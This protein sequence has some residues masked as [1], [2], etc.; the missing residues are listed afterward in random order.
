M[1]V[2][3]LAGSVLKGSTVRLARSA[4]LA[5]VLLVVA[6]CGGSGSAP[7]AEPA[8]S[9]FAAAVGASSDDMLG[10]IVSARMESLLDDEVTRCMKRQGFEYLT[11]DWTVSSS[12][13]VGDPGGDLSD[14]Q[15][16]SELGFGIY[17][18]A[19]APGPTLPDPTT[20][21]SPNDDYLES[22][23]ETERSAWSAQV[24][25]CNRE[26]WAA[27]DRY[28]EILNPLFEAESEIRELVAADRRVVTAT[29]GWVACMSAEGF[30]FEDPETM[31]RS[32][33]DE[34]RTLPESEGGGVVAMGDGP[35]S[36][37]E[38]RAFATREVAVAKA[39]FACSNDLRAIERAV[40]VELE[41]ERLQADPA[42]A[43]A[44]KELLAG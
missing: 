8:T 35:P 6:S 22:L 42:L 13:R 41:E 3:M 4:V 28:H 32:M 26:A 30:Q 24:G 2:A 34:F 37:E 44:L 17:A 43:D 33:L 14:E 9:G 31:F 5:C 20:L 36:S 16:A 39:S 18:I 10:D 27:Q 29:S 11:E 1:L 21:T 23:S 40:R 7:V 19:S 38:G 12:G 15:Y 25:T